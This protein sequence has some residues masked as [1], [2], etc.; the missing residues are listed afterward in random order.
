MIDDLDFETIGNNDKTYNTNRFGWQFG[1]LWENAFTMPNLSLAVEYTRLDPFMY[2]HKSNKNSYTNWTM[3]LGHK[4]QPNSDELALNFGYDITSRIHLSFIYQYQRS[5]GGFLFDSSGNI[6]QNYG[7]DINRGD[8]WYIEKNRFLQGDRT[9]RNIFT[10]TCIIEPIKQY[11]LEAKFYYRNSNLV[12]LNKSYND[13]YFW[14]SA[15]ID[16]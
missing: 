1:G 7:G 6:K 3:S 16:Y 11:Y 15:K 8:Y 12:Y 4:L 10:L 9:N 2:A 13:F 5:G 14:I